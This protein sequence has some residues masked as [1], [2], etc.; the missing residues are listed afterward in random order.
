MRAVC[1]EEIEMGDSAVKRILILDDEPNI[2]NAL[3]RELSVGDTYGYDY[4]I[5]TFTV[6]AEA[7]LR[8]EHQSFHLALSDFRMP[9]M[10]GL[11]FLKALS[12][13]QPDCARIVIS[14]QTDLVALSKM[15]NETHIFRFIAKPWSEE[16]L[17]HSVAHALEFNA[18]RVSNR[19]LAEEVR[20]LNLPIP[21]AAEPRFDQILLVDDDPH[22]LAS[23]SRKLTHRSQM[24]E[25]YMAIHSEIGVLPTVALEERKIG[26]QVTASP[27]HALEM[28]DKIKFSC[29]IADFMMRE[30][31]GV[32]LLAQFRAKQPDCVPILISGQIEQGELIKAM[33][34]AGIFGLIN[35]PW[36]DFEIKA[37]IAQALAYRHMLLENARLA[38]M[39]REVQRELD[40]Q[41]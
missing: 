40:A 13:L 32:E 35:K 21:E 20:N 2:V 15:V 23:L 7:L 18:V 4:Q 3:R 37:L 10:D 1:A 34:S 24:D 5:E 11:E 14:G 30:M 6:P 28:A 25:L 19:M 41:A 31:S 9:G 16:H 27:I 39:V 38:D 12:R 29:V 26:V 8:A 36:Q 33:D 17:M 22:V